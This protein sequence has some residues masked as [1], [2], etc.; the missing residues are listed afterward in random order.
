[1]E[2]VMILRH[3]DP[4]WLEAKRQLSK[5]AVTHANCFPARY[6]FLVT[7]WQSIRFGLNNISNNLRM[8]TACKVPWYLNMKHLALIEIDRKR[9]R[10]GKMG[11]WNAREY[12]VR[13]KSSLN[14]HLPI[15][16]MGVC[17]QVDMVLD[18]RSK[19]LGFDSHCWSCLE[20]LDKLLIPYCLCLPSTDG[21]L[22]D[23]NRLLSG[24]SH[25]HTCLTHALYSP[26]EDEIPQILCVL[27]QGR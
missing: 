18:S 7:T 20:V 1:M 26:R 22:V 27:Y 23:E 12:L 3:S 8:S 24:S 6:I 9:E 19:G 10:G 21:Y 17:G 5:T 13:F 25:L 16:R 4:T 11:Q 2:A 14:W 15:N